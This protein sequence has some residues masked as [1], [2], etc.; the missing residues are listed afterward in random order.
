MDMQKYL[1][2]FVS[3]ATEHI[4]AAGNDA[5]RLAAG[6]MPL[7]TL[8]SLFRH[9]H[10][11]KGMAASMGFEE[12]TALSHSVEDLFDRLRK[13]AQPPAELSELVLE[14]L[15][16]ASTM[17]AWASRGESRGEIS[18][19]AR[20]L[21]DRI[22]AV[23]P[24]LTS[25]PAA[26]A[27]APATA[28]PAAPAGTCY[29][30]H[31]V[32]D[33]R[34]DFPGA[35]AAL[36]LKRLEVVGQV[37][38]S[39]PARG[40]LQRPDF[41]GEMT[42]EL[43]SDRAEGSIR[44][45]VNDLL[46]VKLFEVRPAPQRPAAAAPGPEPVEAGPTTVR[47]PTATLDQFLDAISEMITRRGMLSSAITTR[48]F[49]AARESLGKLSESIDALRKQVMLIRLMPFEHITP[50]L[51][52]SVR[53]LGRRTG[54]R[55][56]LR[57]TGA[58][59]ALDR[60]V[61]E[62]IID[63]LNHILRNAVDHGI[64]IPAERELMGKRPE[65]CISIDLARHGDHVVIGVED[66]GKGMDKEAIR[67]AA[68]AGGFATEA[69]L[70][71]MDEH[72]IFLLTTIPGF[73]T[74]TRV[75]EVSGRGVGMDVVRTRIEALHGHITISSRRGQGTRLEM[76]LPLT[77]AVIDAFVVESG[78]GLFAVPAGSVASVELVESGRIRRTI[79]G[80]F[81]ASRAAPNVDDPSGT[82]EPVSYTPL[83]S[84][85]EAF[86]APASVAQEAPQLRQ[87]LAYQTNG[88]RG[89]LAVDRIRERRE[90]VVKPLGPPLERLRKYSG[91]AL[92]DDGSVALILDLVN[93]SRS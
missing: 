61:L 82:D 27:A 60:S 18:V 22:R 84:L 6:L 45:M 81:L 51:T 64:E 66:D 59:V 24:S 4:Q 30:C 75:T 47:I 40:D 79:S 54:K 88:M 89:A 31:V 39:A 49:H 55:V 9:F 74:A 33:P 77:V 53:D 44:A 26:A 70:A 16:S 5:S 38:S 17:V 63:P 78:A 92:L 20:P 23:T 7:E 41:T 73:S 87:V 48:D 29:E 50:R 35:R 42:I 15:D 72:Q 34:A 80:Q 19:D 28:A 52:R 90:V 43:I 14:A 32:I 93:L 91:A 8:N 21:I 68:L 67:R 71:A 76:S 13:G 1:D 57:I 85:D 3:E 58:E 65:G 37:A 46:D 62:E 86:G 36:V 25:R 10:S 12:I 2:L 11:I 56:S 69:G 83:V